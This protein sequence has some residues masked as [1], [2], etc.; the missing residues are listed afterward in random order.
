MHDHRLLRLRLLTALPRLAADLMFP[1]VCL[2]CNAPLGPECGFTCSR[3][4]SAMGDVDEWD[5]RCRS[6]RANLCAGGAVAGFVPLWYFEEG[7]PVQALVHA[8]KYEGMT[9]VGMDLGRALGARILESGYG[10]ADAIV[11]LPL[12][13]SR[14]RERGFNQADMIARGVSS[15]TGIPVAPSLVRRCRSTPSQTALAPGER[16]ANVC[17]AFRPAR[18]VARGAGATLLLVDDVVTTGATMRECAGTLRA[19]G[20]RAVIACAAALAR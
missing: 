7:G 14:L 18:S 11:P 1:P 6:A 17:G 9:A 16:R 2:A 3:C 4:R 15:V 19:A 8:L 12:H 13:P 20:A 10:G 5:E